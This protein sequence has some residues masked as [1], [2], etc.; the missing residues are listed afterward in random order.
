MR[1]FVRILG[2][3]GMLALTLFSVAQSASADVCGTRYLNCLNRCNGEVD[4]SCRC[5]QTYA[6][7]EGLPV[8]DC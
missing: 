1:G 4:C 6:V 7:C 2:L 5:D 8:P 3:V